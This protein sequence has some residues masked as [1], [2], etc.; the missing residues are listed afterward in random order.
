MEKV[1]N[2]FKNKTIGYYLAC[3]AALLTFMGQFK[4]PQQVKVIR[5]KLVFKLE[6][7]KLLLAKGMQEK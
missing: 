6:E 2:F 7:I 5:E 1:L 3:G 4:D